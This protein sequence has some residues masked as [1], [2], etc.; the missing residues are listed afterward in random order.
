MFWS[1]EDYNNNKNKHSK[2]DIR[3]ISELK[4]KFKEAWEPKKSA[5]QPYFAKVRTFYEKLRK[6]INDLIDED[7]KAVINFLTKVKYH[8]LPLEASSQAYL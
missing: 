7:E 6:G 5:V 4:E 8:H 1:E 2:T 3:L